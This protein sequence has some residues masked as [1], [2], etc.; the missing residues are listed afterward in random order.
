MNTEWADSKSSHEEVWIR[1]IKCGWEGW[2]MM[3][4]EYGLSSL[5]VE[6]CPLKG[7]GMPVELSDD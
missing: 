7:C 4:E 3:I 2:A 1:C 6:E 5:S